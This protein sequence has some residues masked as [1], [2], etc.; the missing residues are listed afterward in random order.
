[1]TAMRVKVKFMGQL[2]SAAGRREVDVEVR[3]EAT[4]LGALDEALRAVPSSVRPMVIDG[5]SSCNSNTII[6]VGGRELRSLGGLK[7]EVK[8]GDEIILLPVVHSG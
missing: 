6:L 8:D 1:M 5:G 4:V 2:E 7:A 3:G